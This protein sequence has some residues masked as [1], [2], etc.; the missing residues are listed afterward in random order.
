[1]SMAKRTT[2]QSNLTMLQNLKRQAAL[3]IVLVTGLSTSPLQADVD[4][5]VED[6]AYLLCGGC[7]GPTNIR[8]MEDMSPNIIGQKRDYI[9]KQLR[10][11]RDGKRS[12]P[13]MNDAMAPYSDKNIEDLANYYAN[14]TVD[15]PGST[16]NTQSV[17]KDADTKTHAHAH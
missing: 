10:A 17:A 13:Y 14:S 16:S 11:F 12:H 4:T 6:T 7:H 9:A 3:M 15:L 2:I 5:P 1:M 8:T